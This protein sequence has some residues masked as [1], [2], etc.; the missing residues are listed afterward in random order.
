MLEIAER[1]A[2]EASVACL[3]ISGDLGTLRCPG[4]LVRVISGRGT[5]VAASLGAAYVV[6][7]NED[8]FPALWRVRSGRNGL[9][10][11]VLKHG[12][13]SL[14][15]V[16]VLGCQTR[17]R[18]ESKKVGAVTG[19]PSADHDPPVK[20]LSLSIYIGTRKMVNYA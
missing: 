16:R 10:H 20:D 11:P 8:L 5:R 19:A 1:E 13:R 18:S 4:V 14:T 6:P 12:P 9:N 15:Y 17:A 2:I 3:D 7:R